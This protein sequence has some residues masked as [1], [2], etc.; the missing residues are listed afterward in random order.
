MNILI[1]DAAHGLVASAER[2]EHGLVTVSDS[3]DVV[4]SFVGLIPCSEAIREHS[5]RGRVDTDAPL[6]TAVDAVTGFGHDG[7]EERDEDEENDHSVEFG[8]FGYLWH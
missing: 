6:T 2:A 5:L 7:A 1:A 8:H 3:S 4:S